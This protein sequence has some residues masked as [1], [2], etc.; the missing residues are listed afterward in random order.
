MSSNKKPKLTLCNVMFSVCLS[1]VSFVMENRLIG[2]KIFVLIIIKRREIRLSLSDK[3]NIIRTIFAINRRE[4]TNQIS[5]GKRS[6]TTLH[7]N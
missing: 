5:P 6:S 2:V 3:F 4:R 7:V 1:V